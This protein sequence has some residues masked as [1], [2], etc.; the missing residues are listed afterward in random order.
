MI[1]VQSEPS[2]TCSGCGFRGPI[3][4]LVIGTSQIRVCESCWNR[5][6]GARLQLAIGG[7]ESVEIL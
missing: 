1:R 7:L 4:L 2:R 3:T 6:A 5:L